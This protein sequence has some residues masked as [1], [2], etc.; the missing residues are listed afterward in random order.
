MD[1]R[2]IALPD[3]LPILPLF[4]VV[5]FPLVVLPL[6]VGQAASIQLIDEA[7]AAEQLVGVVTIKPHARRPGSVALAECHRIG[8]L[9]RVHR[10]LRLPD[11]TLRIAI[12]G[13][14]RIEILDATHE[15]QYLRARARLAPETRVSAAQTRSAIRELSKLAGEVLDRMPGSQAELRTQIAAQ[16]D[17]RQLAYLLASTLLLRADAAEK[18]QFLELP[19]VQEKLAQLK[20]WMVRE[21][22]ALANVPRQPAIDTNEQRQ[23]S[24]GAQQRSRQDVESLRRALETSAVSSEARSHATRELDR[25]ASASSPGEYAAARSYL[26]ALLA[27]PW[28]PPAPAVPDVAVARQALQAIDGHEAAKRRLLESSATA[29]MRHTRQGTVAP[30]AHSTTLCL[31]GPP[32][33][34]KGT[35]VRA[36]AS[37][38][39]RKC[40]RIPVAALR[41]AAGLVGAPGM[42]PGA[43]LEALSRA[44]AANPLL[45][46]D[47]I[48]HARL[49]S[50]GT[51]LAALVGLLDPQQRQVFRDRYLAITWDLTPVAFV[52]TADNADAIPVALREYLELIELAG[53]TPTEKLAIARDHLV[54][55]QLSEH[56]LTA[57]DV[58]FTDEALRTIIEEY[59]N[60]AGVLAC[61]RAIAAICRNMTLALLELSAAT[62]P[63]GDARPIVVDTQRVRSELG[64]PVPSAS[65]D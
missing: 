22:D 2:P 40:E 33:V 3:D 20:T 18:Q 14:E 53:Y 19:T 26:Q 64:S 8:V 46:L 15:H 23:A 42:A 29:V 57:A 6:A 9:A 62:A 65:S 63:P 51:L 35:L 36:L 11:N 50:A 49:D 48:D 55:T 5:A 12:E 41:D 47:G 1:E 60:E 28:A 59:T 4:N 52:A 16:T 37:G 31:V 58:Q 39:G 44:G 25:M 32:G 7:I 43:M 38:L 34:G 17:A 27:L 13:L 45:L 56:G 30:G 24:H 61:E 21:R 54:P 10:L